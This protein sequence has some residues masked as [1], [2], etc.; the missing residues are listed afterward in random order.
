MAHDRRG[1]GE[2]LVFGLVAGALLV[3]LTWWWG[4]LPFQEKTDEHGTTAL[5]RAAAA[6]DEAAV[7]RLIRDGARVNARVPSNDLAVLISILQF[8]S[9]VA[10]HDVGWTPLMYAAQGGHEPVARRLLAAGAD[11]RLGGRLGDTALAVAS[12]PG[13][14]RLL[15]EAGADVNVRSY[16]QRRTPLHAAVARH[17]AES[18]KALVAARADV[19][20]ADQEGVTPLLLAARLG[21]GGLVTALLAA[22]ADPAARDQRAGW[23]P[24]RWAIAEGHTAVADLLRGSGAPGEGRNDAALLDALQ[25]KDA[26]GVQAA[27]QAGADPNARNRFGDTAL[28]MASVRGETEAAVALLRAGADPNGGPRAIRE[29]LLEAVQRGNLDL[30]RAL[31]DAGAAVKTSKHALLGAAAAGGHAGIAEVLLQAGADVNQSGGEPLRAAAGR[32][33]VEL[34]RR[35]LAAGADPRLKDAAERTA[36]GQAAAFGHLEAVKV[37]VAAGAEVHAKGGSGYT[38]LMSAASNGHAEVV[39]FLA[40]A[41]ADVHARDREGKTALGYARQFR[42]PAAEQALLEAGARE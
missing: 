12:R 30:V 37:L 6:G 41:G 9:P 32:G 36:L 13:M 27:L 35:L 42:Q 24:L 1:Y 14:I 8:F 25:R 18:V 40:R 33:H 2:R 16:P 26:G 17:D 10:K 19:N 11:V 15:V 31:V 39:R 34:V 28:G 23:T 22:G 3:L 21:D 29:P 20:A 38:P 4:W 5:M 7:D